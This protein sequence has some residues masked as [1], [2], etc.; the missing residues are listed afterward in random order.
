MPGAVGMEESSKIADERVRTAMVAIA[1]A[2]LIIIAVFVVLIPDRVGEIREDLKVGDYYIYES[3]NYTMRNE[4]L[5]F[6][7][8]GDL[9]VLHKVNEEE[10]VDTMTK[11]EFLGWIKYDKYDDPRIRFLGLANMDTVHGDKMCHIYSNMLNTYLVD[12]YS[13][14]YHQAVGGVYW[15]LKDTNM[16]YGVD[17]IYGVKAYGDGIREGAGAE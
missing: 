7:E 10:Y 2:V 8:N 17:P 4:I 14:V 5:E 12:E 6:E 9:K 16:L 13:V 11:E 15:T 1:L 3:Q